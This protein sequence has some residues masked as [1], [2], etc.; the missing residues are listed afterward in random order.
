MLG[1]ALLAYCPCPFF[2]FNTFQTYIVVIQRVAYAFL[3]LVWL[4][5]ISKEMRSMQRSI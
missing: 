5:G 3:A 4:L 1:N 2:F